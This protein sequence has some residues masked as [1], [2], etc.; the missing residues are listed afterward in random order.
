MTA[1]RRLLNAGRRILDRLFPA[2]H[3]IDLILAG[4]DPMSR[5]EAEYK[6]NAK[7]TEGKP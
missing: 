5:L 1:V 4:R 7:P 6:A 3:Q 2:P